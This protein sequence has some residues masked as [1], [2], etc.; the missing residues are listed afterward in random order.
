MSVEVRLDRDA[1]ERYLRAR[2]G[3]AGRDIQRRTARVKALAEVGAPGRMGDAVDSD[4]YQGPEGLVGEVTVTHPAVFYVMDGTRPH[5]IRPRR[6]KALRFEARGSVVFAKL[7]R[8][9]GT[10][11]NPF[12]RRAL[13][14]GG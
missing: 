2:G 3:P 12:L 5:L 13:E 10:R 11:A 6:K 8:H 4:V 7:V 9:P 1:L 14:L